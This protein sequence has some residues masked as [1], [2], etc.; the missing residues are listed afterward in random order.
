ML[1]PEHLVVPVGVAVVDPLFL[2]TADV[3]DDPRAVRV[4]GLVI[5]TRKHFHHVV[6][7]VASVRSAGGLCLPEK[8]KSVDRPVASVLVVGGGCRL[9]PTETSAVTDLGLAVVG[10]TFLG[11]HEDHTVGG[12]GSVDSRRGG[13]LDYGDALDI[14]RIDILKVAQGT[15]DKDDRAGFVDRS[16]TADVQFSGTARITGLGRDVESRNRPLKHCH[17]VV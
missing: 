14:I 9:L 12:A 7:G 16:E 4:L 13:V 17:K 5:D 8:V 2:A 11:G 15:V 10:V 6:L 1:I 3:L